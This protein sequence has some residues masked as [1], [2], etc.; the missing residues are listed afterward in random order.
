M[1]KDT[2]IV[3]FRRDLRLHDNPAWNAATN[4]GCAIIPLF[5]HSPNEDGKWR[6][7]AA[8]N[9]WLHHA[10]KDLS[11]QLET[12]GLS[13]ILRSSESSLSEL[14]ALTLESPVKAVYWNRCYEEQS[15]NRDTLIKKALAADAI[16]VKTFNGSLLFD[17]LKIA[18]KSG[19]PYK[20]FTPFW[21][22]CLTLELKAPDTSPANKSVHNAPQELKSDSLDALKL[23]PTIPWDTDMAQF[24]QPTRSGGQKLLKQAIAKSS[25]YLEFRDIP[26][27][28]GTSRLSPYLHFGQISPT[29][30]HHEVLTHCTAKDL[31]HNGMLRQLFWR[32]FSAHLLYHF[33]HTHD[34]PLRNEYQSFPWDYDTELLTKWQRGQTGYPIVDAGMRQLWKT[35]WMHNRVRMV[36][37]SFLVKHLLQPWQEGAHWFWDTLVDADLANNTQGWQW[38]G[39]CGADA[40][41]YFRVF[42]PILQSKKFDPDATYIKKWL[43]ELRNIPTDQIHAPWEMEPLE[44]EAAGVKL[45]TEYP[46][47]I[48]GHQEGRQQ[49]LDAYSKFKDS[50]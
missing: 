20:V 19:L 47:P 11:T 46:F 10:L 25:H 8:S 34:Q 16:E 13:L 24:W 30:F 23:L 45:G 31:A 40:S 2:C 38:I 42:N 22:A 14:T 1:S 49:A 41:P 29:E 21:K 44:L 6:R 28:D 50:L 18:N 33:P 27:D 17:P 15:I 9:W 39:G 12:H 4:S 43:P 35:G 5:I 36:A 32:E 48:I 3:W 26:S 7:G 37:S